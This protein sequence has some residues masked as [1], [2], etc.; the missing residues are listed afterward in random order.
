MS[1]LQNELLW[2]N[3]GESTSKAITFSIDREIVV[4]TNGD[5]LSK[6]RSEKTL[7]LNV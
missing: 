4:W 5:K 1:K 6:Y 3:M 7:K 2:L